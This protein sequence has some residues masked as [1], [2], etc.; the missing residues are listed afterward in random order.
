M[1][2]NTRKYL[3]G[4]SKRK[5]KEEQDNAKRKY[6]G[7]M[8]KYVLNQGKLLRLTIYSYNLY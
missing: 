7:L 4:A 2:T 8:E 3:S 5:K 1:S 6:Q